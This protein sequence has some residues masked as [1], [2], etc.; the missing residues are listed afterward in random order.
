MPGLRRVLG[1]LQTD[2][3]S[4]WNSIWNCRTKRLDSVGMHRC[5]CWETVLIWVDFGYPR[6]AGFGPGFVS[7]P[8]AR[9]GIVFRSTSNALLLYRV[10]RSE[11]NCLPKECLHHQCSKYY[12]RGKDA[13]LSYT[14]KAAAPPPHGEEEGGRPGEARCYVSM[15]P[16]P[17]SI[18]I[19]NSCTTPHFFPERSG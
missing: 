18:Y 6:G 12:C 3:S 1:Q 10:V 16:R 15:C 14:T 17:R 8:D 2:E 5:W 19:H 7:A 4:G 11:S 9:K 13:T